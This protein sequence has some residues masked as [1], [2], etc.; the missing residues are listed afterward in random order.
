MKD[1]NKLTS[2]Q[3]IETD[4]NVIGVGIGRKIKNGILTKEIG[5]TYTVK[6]KLPIDQI[7]EGKRILKTIKHEGK[8]YNTDVI[9][10]EIRPLMDWCYDEFYQWMPQYPTPVEPTN[11]DQIR[12]LKGGISCTNYTNMPTSTGT[13]GFLAVDNED[14]TLV[15]VSNAHVIVNNA[16]LAPYRTTGTI[17]NTKN[18]LIVQPA[19]GDGGTDYIG[20]IKRFKPWRTGA[21][22][23]FIDC[24]L[25]TIDDTD[26]D[27]SQSWKIE[28]LT[29]YTAGMLWASTDEINNIL[30]N[31]YNLYAAG[32]TTG[33]KGEGRTKMKLSSIF[34]ANTISY[35]Y[36]SVNYNDLFTMVATD[37]SGGLCYLP[38]NPGDS[39]SVVYADVDG[40][41]TKK[42]IGLVLAGLISGTVNNPWTGTPVDN[43]TTAICCR[44]DRIKTLMNISP[45]TGQ[46]NLDFSDRNNIEEYILEGLSDVESI[47]VAGKK[48]FLAGLTS[49]TGN[50]T[51]TTST[52]V[53][54]TTTTTSNITTT[55]TTA[56]ASLSCSATNIFEYAHSS[57]TVDGMMF[58]GERKQNPYIIKF[59]DPDD[60]NSYTGVTVSDV[61][62]EY[63]G[64]ENVCSS[65]STMYFGTIETTTGYLV[66][67]ECGTDLTF[68]KHTYP[69]IDVWNFAITT[70]GT[71]I[72]GGTDYEFF[73]IRIS[74]WELIQKAKFYNDFTSTHAAAYSA[75]R[76]EVYLTS[77][78]T[79]EKLAIL[80][81][82]D[83]WT[84]TIVDLSS[85]TNTLTDDM[86]YYSNKLYIG[87]ELGGC[88]IVDLAN[89]NSITPLTISETY[90]LFLNGTN[91]YS[92]KISGYIEKFSVSTP[93]SVA[94]YKLESGFTPNEILF[95]GSRVFVTKWAGPGTAK[96]C[97]M[98]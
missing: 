78:G 24:A 9:E 43:Y 31:D 80:D 56:L 38:V 75:T 28:G 87:S 60:L 18:N 11:R 14:N 92:C 86:V 95:V 30:E 29:G 12:P 79:T 41:G 39:G 48:Y 73:K 52:T 64:L 54:T 82:D 81:A 33:S 70:D 23:N 53:L 5:I 69:T 98:T 46:T 66:I 32:R 68:T 10:G 93:D 61:G 91:I 8:T 49:T 35:S 1:L 22:D 45:Y 36:V 25:C 6:K 72:Y 26:I 76:N 27:N 4:D 71:Y 89:N 58:I 83:I 67:V 20:A 42:I 55:T 15:G 57:I 90:G 17:D 16:L 77:Q 51:T 59:D 96:L 63:I 3:L 62:N 88:I 37:G 50:T 13:L 21:T 34:Y 65:G 97:E 2:K 7:P 19:S 44:I 84:Y 74:D 85:Y 40:S 94:V 47:T